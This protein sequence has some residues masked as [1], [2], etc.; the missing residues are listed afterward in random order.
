M[1]RGNYEFDVDENG[2]LKNSAYNLEQLR[3]LWLDRDNIDG[4]DIG[5]GDPGD[6]DNGAWHVACHLLGGG[7]V[8]KLANGKLA[9][10]QVSYNSA[11]D[12]YFASATVRQD[13]AT[14][15]VLLDSA[16]GRTL[17]ADSKL[18]GF[19]EG[20]S[21]GRVSARY[22]SDPPSLFNLWRRQDFDQPPGST[23]D[24]G[25]VWEHWCTLR[26]IRPAHAIGT[27][28]LTAYVSLVAALGD[29][30]IPCVARGR[31]EYGHPVQLRAM[32]R[33]GLVGRASATWDGKPSPISKEAEK[34]FLEADEAAALE[35]ASPRMASARK[36]WRNSPTS[37]PSNPIRRAS[38][39]CGTCRWSAARISST[40]SASTTRNIARSLPGRQRRSTSRR[41]AG[42]RNGRC[43]R[44]S[45][46]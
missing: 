10:L 43:C 7:G 9:W 6:F 25:R 40:A 16:E 31:R 29:L 23:Q 24:G 12:R 1:Y 17:L 21:V 2:N 30:F 41:S 18:L 36:C 26:D 8:R 14:R 3:K 45:R 22:V 42:R 32:V 13:K 38:P 35:A 5:P 11:T 34:L 20:T 4:G 15:I 39:A 27:S 37:C 33:A 19:V 28:V 44:R 46:N